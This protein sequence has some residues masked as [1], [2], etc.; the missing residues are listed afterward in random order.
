MIVVSDTSPIL[1]LL[2]ID[3]LDLLPR[4]Y[5]R[6]IIP[7]VVQAEMQN[8]GAP[9][10]LQ[11]W[12]SAPPNWLEIHPVSNTANSAPKD[13]RTLLQR[14]DPGEQAAILL[15]QSL[16]A[17]LLIVDDLD[18]RQTA[19]NLGINITGMLGILGEAAKRN[20]I[21]FSETLERLVQ[22]TNFR[23][24]PKLIQALLDQFSNSQ[25]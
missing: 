23:A 20:W 16:N 17:D 14:L 19:Q 15:A 11:N 22:E 2:L 24:S 5:Q 12:I 25:G 8:P 9:L 21:N 4:L 10:A 18:A 3:Q 13:V 1:Y 6:I 7:D